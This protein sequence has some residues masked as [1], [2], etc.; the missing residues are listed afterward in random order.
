MVE[1]AAGRSGCGRPVPIRSRRKVR[2]T[3]LGRMGPGK[4]NDFRG[5]EEAMRAHIGDRLVLEGTH[6]DDRRRIG[7]ITENPHPEGT[8]P[9]RGGWPDGHE[10]LVVPGPD[11][12]VEAAPTDVDA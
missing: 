10:T 12:R 7:V 9:N 2:F 8:P 3:V 4:I 5:V 6:V 11:G 1:A